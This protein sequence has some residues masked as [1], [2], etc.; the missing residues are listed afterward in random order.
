LEPLQRALLAFYTG[1]LLF[2]DASAAT[3]KSSVNRLHEIVFYWSSANTQIVRRVTSAVRVSGS[4]YS[5]K[6]PCGGAASSP[7]SA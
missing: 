4:A 3:S 7:S 6:P 5:S 2:D 1:A